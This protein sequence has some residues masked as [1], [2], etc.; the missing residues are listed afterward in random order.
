MRQEYGA[1]FFFLLETHVS[2]ARGEQIRKNMGFDKSFVVD[3]VGHARGIWC[4]WD[5]STWKVDILEHDKQFVHLKISSNNSNPWLITA[6]HGSPHGCL[7][8]H[9][10]T[11]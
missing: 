8:D 7:E 9:Y 5:S 1:N 3:V 2:S 4:L 10:G 6:V 11:P